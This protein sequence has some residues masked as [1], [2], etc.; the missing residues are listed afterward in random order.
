[1]LQEW[2]DNMRDLADLNAQIEA[3]YWAKVAALATLVSIVVSVGALMGLF[4]SLRQTHHSLNEN[5]RTGALERRPWLVIKDLNILNGVQKNIDGRSEFVAEVEIIVENTG[6]SPAF[7][8]NLVCE[9]SWDEN[10]ADAALEA[11]EESALYGSAI[12]PAQSITKEIR[13]ARLAHEGAVSASTLSIE[14]AVAYTAKEKRE[15]AETVATATVID[16]HTG[17]VIE[18]RQLQHTYHKMK[19]G[20]L[21]HI[22]MS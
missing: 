11:L 16:R 13:Y 12:Y 6:L 14:V 15:R 22:G 3:A 9:Y 20:A 18:V 7:D 1:M 8:A 5:R 21:V 17:Y 2:F 4:I 10:G 19:L